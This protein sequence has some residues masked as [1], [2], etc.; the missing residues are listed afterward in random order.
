MA[1]AHTLLPAHVQ[2]VL[3]D[4]DLGEGPSVSVV[5]N[6]ARDPP[7]TLAIRRWLLATSRLRRGEG[8]G[9]S[10]CSN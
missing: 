9:V 4:V 10:T 6:A 7:T 5:V 3:S 8:G 2:W 1:A